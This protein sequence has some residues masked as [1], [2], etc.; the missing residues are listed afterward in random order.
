[1]IEII[2]WYVGSVIISYF[3]WRLYL[4]RDKYADCNPF[5]FILLVML[6]PGFNIIL[7]LISMVIDEIGKLEHRFNYKKFF[8]LL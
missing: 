6:M 3:L 1:M 4:K 5:I 7:P 2:L 8:R